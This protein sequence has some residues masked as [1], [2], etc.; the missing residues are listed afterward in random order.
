MFNMS[1]ECLESGLQNLMEL[2]PPPDYTFD[3]PDECLEYAQRF[4]KEQGY[5]LM[6]K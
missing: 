5:A 4:A 6:T 2:L 3:T 1:E